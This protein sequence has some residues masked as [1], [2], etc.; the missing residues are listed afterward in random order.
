MNDTPVSYPAPVALFAYR[1][2]DHLRRTVASLLANPEAARTRLI[3][4]CDAAARPQHQADAAAVRAYVEGIEGFAAVEVIHRPHNLGLAGNIIDGVGRVA[5]RF[6][7]V[8]VVEDDLLVSPHFLRF[9]N[10]GLSLYA[11]E[12]RVASIHAYTY[13]VAQ[14]LPET[15]F[16]RGADCWGWATWRRAWQHFR[17]DGTAL[18]AELRSRGL[19]AEFDLDGSY[20][21]STMLRDQIAGRNDSWAVRWHA[22]CYLDDLLTLYPGRS[23]VH[24]IGNDA[25]G[26]HGED[27]DVYTQLP[28]LDPVA[29]EPLPLQPSAQARSA[30]VEY[31]RSLK[32]NPMQRLGRALRRLARS[33]A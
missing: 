23:L 18:L 10:D 12:P 32:P 26:T 13:P 6:G 15:F 25:S 5:E 2:P 8:I 24:N 28:A 11:Q 20:A 19:M 4:F 9:M 1:R 7:H 33:S 16:L 30:F 31:F 22:A 29:V 14:R 27:R 17:P 21:Y 3:A